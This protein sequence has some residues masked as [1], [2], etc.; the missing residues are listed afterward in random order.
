MDAA[1]RSE[2]ANRVT[3]HDT[4][5]LRVAAIDTT[6]SERGAFSYPD[7][8]AGNA[9][10]VA[11]NAAITCLTANGPVGFFQWFAIRG[12]IFAKRANELL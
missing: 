12:T 8:L 10:R 2:L 1:A 6:G 9:L 4:P 11:M 3:A 7:T 5:D